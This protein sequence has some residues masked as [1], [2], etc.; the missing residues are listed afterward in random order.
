MKLV[1]ERDT[2]GSWLCDTD[3]WTWGYG[4]GGTPEEAVADL[5]STLCEARD[6]G[7]LRDRDW[8]DRR[9]ARTAL[10]FIEGRVRLVDRWRAMWARVV[11]WWVE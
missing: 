8:S 3:P 2:D 5:R 10:D 9:G 4:Y 11:R 1:I 7:W 6:M